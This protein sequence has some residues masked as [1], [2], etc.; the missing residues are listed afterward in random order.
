MTKRKTTKLVTD[1]DA[2]LAALKKLRNKSDDT[3]LRDSSDYLDTLNEIEPSNKDN[4]LNTEQLGDEYI[5]PTNMEME[6]GDVEDVDPTEDLT[7]LVEKLSKPSNYTMGEILVADDEEAEAMPQMNKTWVAEDEDNV[8]W[9]DEGLLS[10]DEDP[11]LDNADYDPDN[12]DDDDL[13]D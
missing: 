11:Y 6:V 12:P 2:S 8:V 5:D 9:V 13:Y 1:L 4:V 3:D 7:E 10:E